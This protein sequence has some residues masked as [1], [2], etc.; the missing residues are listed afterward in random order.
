MVFSLLSKTDIGYTFYQ[1]PSKEKRGNFDKKSPGDRGI[2]AG[3]PREG[4]TFP[5]LQKIV[6]LLWCLWGNQLFL[7]VS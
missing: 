6:I 5:G 2:F 3:Q 7:Y 1:E 4:W